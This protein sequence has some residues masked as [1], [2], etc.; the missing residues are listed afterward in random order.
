MTTATASPR[1]I[2]HFADIED[3]RREHNRQ[4]NLFDILII[5]FCAVISKAESWEDIAEFGRSKHAWF[6]TFLTLPNGIPSHDTFHRVFNLLDPS[7]ML[8]A[9]SSWLAVLA[10]NNQGRIVPIDGKTLRGSLDKAGGKAALHLVSAWAAEQHLSLGQ[11]AVEGKSNEIAAIP[12]L[13]EMLDLMGAIVTIDALGC[14]KEIAAEIRDAGADY[15]LQLKDNHPTLAQAVRDAFT[16]ALEEDAVTPPSIFE[17]EVEVGHGRRERRTI[18]TLAVPE[19]LFERE[20]WRDLRTLVMVF[21]ERTEGGKTSEEF[22]Y[23]LSSHTAT[24]EEFGRIIRLHWSIE[25]ALHWVLDV[26]F[27]EDKSR[28]QAGNGA[29]NFA[30]LRRLAVS[31]LKQNKEKGS[32]KGK[33]LRAG[34]NNDFLLELL[35]GFQANS[36]A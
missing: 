16:D 4:H 33:S 15:V 13:L 1:L 7:K 6:K 24:A 25:N 36:S 29:E 9:V 18:F 35:L 32:L 31:L 17:G 28:Q 11:V 26:T 14:Q 5:A 10:D 19:D 30:L 27:G 3:P 34:W 22:S 21:R 2:D 12:K 23:Y 8:D 20:L